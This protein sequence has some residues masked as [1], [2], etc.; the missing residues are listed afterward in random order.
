MKHND[1][2]SMLQCW[3]LGVGETRKFGMEY[4]EF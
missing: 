1:D 4:S 3:C 2:V